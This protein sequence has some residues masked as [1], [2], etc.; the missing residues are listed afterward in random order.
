M[1]LRW[2]VTCAVWATLLQ[3][4][5]AQGRFRSD[6]GGRDVSVALFSTETVHKLTLTPL[7]RDAWIASCA[8]CVR[9][10]FTTAMHVREAQE[11]FAGGTLRATNETNSTSASQRSA[12]GLWHVRTVNPGLEI[13]VVLTVPS[14]RYVAAV[15]SA[16]ASP[17]EPQASLQALAIV[18]RTYALNG[19]HFSA[20]FGHLPADL[21]DSTQCQ[22]MRF[23]LVPAAMDDAVRATAG[24]TMWFGGRRAE[25]YFSQHCGGLTED[26]HAV[27]P[28]LRDV[29]YLRSHNDPYCV[30][31]DTAAWHAEVPADALQRIAR[32]QGWRLPQD[33][34]SVHA[35]ARSGSHRV[36]RVTFTGEGGE[37]IAVAGSALRF[38]IDRA[39][40]WNQVRSD[41]YDLT[42]HGG[43]L[44][45]DGRGHGHGVGLC[46]AGA[47]EMAAE[48]KSAREI[49]QFYFAGT[50][51]GITS[52]DEGWLETRVGPM[53]V[54]SVRALTAE[55]RNLLLQTWMEAERRFLPRVPLTPEIV[56]A[57]STEIFRQ[58]TAQP[59][60]MLASTRGAVSV[61]QPETVLHAGGAGGAM[62]LLHEMLHI[63]VEAEANARAPVWLREGLVEFL[64]GEPAGGTPVL[65]AEALDADL[66]HADSLRGSERAH[67]AA[68]VRVGALIAR[69]GRSAVRGWL[70]SGV[71]A[72]AE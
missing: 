27:W 36:L 7:G 56:Y 46:Q 32:D 18:A 66:L 6:G 37:E 9:R 14:E 68:A 64:A 19:P 30:R 50:S 3:T 57:P 15:L 39:L 31:R 53:L 59:G 13:D 61:L 60:W 35:A 2:L 38:G 20:A 43:V 45:F 40:G 21:C 47:T 34:A 69:Y 29:P 65:S 49:L 22:A 17:K 55:E 51:V 71:P 25:A 72:T 42:F 4:G 11:V 5:Q 41:L 52:A 26:A 23:G 63:L 44:V 1:S 33:I 48:G 24:E 10:P 58:L 16:E 70:T 62:T 8:R 12:A 54:R 28:G 67:Y